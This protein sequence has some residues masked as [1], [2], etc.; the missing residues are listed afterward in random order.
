MPIWK[1]KRSSYLFC[2]N[3]VLRRHRENTTELLKQHNQGRKFHSD[4]LRW[5]WLPWGTSVLIYIF[6]N[7]IDIFRIKTYL[8]YAHSIMCK[9]ADTVLFKH[10]KTR[11]YKEDCLIS[12]FI[13]TNIKPLTMLLSPEHP[14]KQ[15][16]Q[17]SSKTARLLQKLYCKICKQRGKYLFQVRKGGN[18]DLKRQFYWAIFFK[19]E[20]TP[21]T[22]SCL[23]KTQKSKH[24][25]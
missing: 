7:F 5:A 13:F 12:P 18:F 15:I 9:K 16:Q 8:E 10:L 14:E 23:W 1:L 24:L 22:F 2:P 11:S 6:T 17:G 25:L 19:L 4:L 3:K 20:E 21:I